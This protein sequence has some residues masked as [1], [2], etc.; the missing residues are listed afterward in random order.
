[1]TRRRT[2]GRSDPYHRLAVA[3]IVPPTPRCEGVDWLAPGA[4]CLAVNGLSVA[5]GSDPYAM[6]DIFLDPDVGE[7]AIVGAG[8]AAA[9]RACDADGGEAAS[10]D[11]EGGQR[12]CFSGLVPFG[13]LADPLPGPM[14]AHPYYRPLPSVRRAVRIAVKI[15]AFFIGAIC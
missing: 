3:A 15:H 10:D 5:A 2:D 1:M 4:V 11:E 6:M 7:L 13:T 8:S 12:R 9:V 14:H